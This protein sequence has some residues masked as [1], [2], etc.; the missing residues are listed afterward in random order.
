MLNRA[1]TVVSAFLVFLCGYLAMKATDW[2]FI[3]AF[4]VLAGLAGLTATAFSRRGR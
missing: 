1:G 3:I 4:T 2:R